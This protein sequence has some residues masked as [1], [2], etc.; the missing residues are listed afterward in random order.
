MAVSDQ[1]QP[2]RAML[3]PCHAVAR[4]IATGDAALVDHIF[5]A[6]P[7]TILEVFAPFLFEGRGAARAYIHAMR[8][9]VAP[10]KQMHYRFGPANDFYVSGDLAS[11]SLP[12]RWRGLSAAVPFTETGGWKFI[13]TRA[14]GAWRVRAYAWGVT[15]YKRG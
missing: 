2:D 10:L 9:H 6:G 11:F 5:A 12:T 7:V 15:A 3:A 13:L 1:M 14:D 8:A 4:F